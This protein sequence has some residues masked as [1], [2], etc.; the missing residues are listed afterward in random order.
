MRCL[1]LL[2]V[3]SVSTHKGESCQRLLR[4]IKSMSSPKWCGVV[5]SNPALIHVNGDKCHKEVDYN[6]HT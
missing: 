3:V 4:G 1:H 6:L 5:R 2:K